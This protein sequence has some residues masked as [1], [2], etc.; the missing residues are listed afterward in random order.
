MSFL[1]ILDAAC[2]E[3]S[4]YLKVRSYLIGQ[5]ISLADLV[6]F[7]AIYDI[8]KHL[9]PQEK[10]NYLHLSRWFDHLQQVPEIRQGAGLINLSSIHLLAN[11][12]K[13]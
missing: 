6:V 9:T 10:E 11:N 5:S 4:S 7:Y 8:M 2:L 12:A 13:A 1:L 3:L